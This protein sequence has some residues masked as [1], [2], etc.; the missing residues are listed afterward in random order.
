MGRSVAVVNYSEFGCLVVHSWEVVNVNSNFWCRSLCL[1]L[2]SGP[3]LGGSVIGSS[4]VFCFVD[5]YLLYIFFTATECRTFL[6]YCVPVL[7]GILPDKYVAHCFLLSKAV[8]LLL[9]DA[10]TSADI[11]L[12]D[13]LLRLFWRL[14]EQYYGKAIEL[15][16]L[17]VCYHMR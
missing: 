6:L 17:A 9:S 14:T 3:L 7:H 4:T 1:L 5:Q 15:V 16:L 13:S 11:E 2:G 8:R 12:A 10:I